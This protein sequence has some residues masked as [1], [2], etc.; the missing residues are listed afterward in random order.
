V[1]L[2]SV[3]ILMLTGYLEYLMGFMPGGY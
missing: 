3:G 2:I 1:L